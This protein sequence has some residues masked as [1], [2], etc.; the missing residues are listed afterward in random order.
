M[1]VRAQI[2]GRNLEAGT[3]V[4][5]IEKCGLLAFIGLLPWCAQPNVI[6]A[7]SQWRFLFPND[8]C[9]CQVDKTKQKQN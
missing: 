7:F 1:K 6:E 3:E 4:E 5:A 2:Q 8:S 9:L